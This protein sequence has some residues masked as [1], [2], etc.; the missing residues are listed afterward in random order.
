MLTIR[1]L[2]AFFAEIHGLCHS[3]EKADEASNVAALRDSLPIAH[4]G[5]LASQALARVNIFLP[6]LTHLGRRKLVNYDEDTDPFL[7]SFVTLALPGAG[8]RKRAL[9]Q[10][11][12]PSMS[13]WYEDH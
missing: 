13:G 10:L 6:A 11:I 8:S 7:A 1:V 4:Q 5:F 2:L 9:T 3:T 12:S